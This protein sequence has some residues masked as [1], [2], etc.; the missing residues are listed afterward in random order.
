MT[1]QPDVLV[2]RTDT[3]VR[4]TLNRPDRLNALTADMMNEAAAVVE[5][6]GD[7]PTV[8]VFVV[9]GNGRAFSSGADLSNSASNGPQV[10]TL[11]A[12]NRL[13]RA[14]RAAPQPVLAAINGPAV[15]VGCSLALAADI[16]VAR[17]SAYFLL[18]FANVGLMPD[19]GAT[20]MVPALIGY[21]RAARMAMLAERIPAPLAAE[22]G[23]IGQVVPDTDYDAEIARLTTKLA[24]GPTAAYTRTKRAFNAMAL[25]QLDQA[26]DLER[27]GQSALFETADVAEGIAAFKAKRT[28]GFIGR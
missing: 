3:I 11:D 7:D 5:K 21:A 1:D 16:T 8:R 12:A 6:F 23:L 9:T 20:A 14:L 25:A 18:A 2:E 10:A 26:L 27:E 28:P 4:L 17:E 15:G 13:I 19:G 24:N 22:W